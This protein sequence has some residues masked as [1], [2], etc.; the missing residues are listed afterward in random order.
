[1]YFTYAATSARD[2]ITKCQRLAL[3]AMSGA[4]SFRGQ[5]DS[6]W[7][8]APS[9]LRR[10]APGFSPPDFETHLLADLHRVLLERTALPKHIVDDVA[11]R[12]ALAQHYRIPTRLSD[13]TRD[14]MVALYFAASD[15]LR[16]V[17]ISGQRDGSFSVFALANIYLSVDQTRRKG[18]FIRPPAGGNPNLTA[19]RAHL[20][21]HAWETP[22]LL[23][24]LSP[25]PTSDPVRNVS[26]LV[27]TRFIRLD[28]GWNHA[29]NVVEHLLRLGLSADLVYPAEDG[30][31]R[32]AADLALG[33][34]LLRLTGG[35]D[36]GAESSEV[37]TPSL[38]DI[39]V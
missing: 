31:V 1:M 30:L 21:M 37:D 8:L 6:R 26:A 2:L 25:R 22:D 7:S 27:D 17:V 35:P 3:I 38:A 14:P 39:D 29:W 24:G 12:L 13:W 28:L 16:E 4:W 9:L 19:Q 18:E 23:A 15:A 11:F 10:V 34:D 33:S 32:L 20:L 36:S 5:A